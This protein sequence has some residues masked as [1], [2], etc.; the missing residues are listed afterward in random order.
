MLCLLHIAAHHLFTTLIQRALCVYRCRQHFEPKKSS[1]LHHR[2][3]LHPWC[4]VHDDVPI[5]QSHAGTVHGAGP[6]GGAS[7]LWHCG[8]DQHKLQSGP[9]ICGEDPYSL[10][11]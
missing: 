10:Q 1:T 9:S 4:H 2:G 5:S 11:M 7:G 3:S 8:C 6:H